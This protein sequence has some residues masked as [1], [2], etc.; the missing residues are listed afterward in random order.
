[1]RHFL[2][3]VIL[4]I[5]G[6]TLVIACNHQISQNIPSS[7]KIPITECRMVK[8]AMGETCVPIH[9]QRVVT[10]SFPTLGNALALG[11][12]P[13]GTTNEVYQEK[14]SLTSKTEG[15]KLLGLSQPNLEATLLLKPDLIIG[16][17]W[18]KVFYPLLSKIAPTVLG[19]LDYSKW[20]KHMS[21][22]AEALGKKDTE[23]ALWKRYHQRMQKLKIALGSRYKDKKISFI[24]IGRNQISIDAKNS[25]AGLII[26]NALLQCPYE[27]LIKRLYLE[28]KII[29]LMALRLQ[30]EVETKAL[31]SN[32]LI[33]PDVLDK[34]YYTKNILEHN[35][36]NP[37][38]LSELAEQ[39]KLSHHQLK[40]GF[41]QIFGM[42][43]FQYL[44]Q[45]R[46]DKARQL[47]Y[48]GNMRIAEVANIVGYSHL[49]R[50]A[51]AFKKKFGIS[52]S[53]CLKGDVCRTSD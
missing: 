27:G 40:C 21:F 19:E 20:E 53:Q 36:E 7:L 13:I 30:Q 23:K 46:L 6:F 34:I 45:Y 17:D 42:T 14:N 25:F 50:F 37:P 3:W 8:H 15:I 52:P 32:E 47:L 22:V 4:G 1:M 31:Y 38:S 35:L 26:S 16:L 43:I 5:F 11:V 29:E 24:Y 28:S 49:G 12:K 39:V 51:G 18:L 41:R 48:E 33:K 10:L 2:C 44:H 9:P